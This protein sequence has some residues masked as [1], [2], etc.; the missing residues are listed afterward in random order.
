MGTNPFNSS[1][2]TSLHPSLDISGYLVIRTF[3]IF[4]PVAKRLHLQ[5][6]ENIWSLIMFGCQHTPNDFLCVDLDR[7]VGVK[8]HL[9]RCSHKKLSKYQFSVESLL[10]GKHTMIKHLVQDYTECVNISLQCICFTLNEHFR[11]H[12]G[13]STHKAAFFILQPR[14]KKFCQPKINEFHV[15]PIL[16]AQNIFWLDV[17]VYDIQS[18]QSFYTLKKLIEQLQYCYFSLLCRAQSQE[19][20]TMQQLAQ[21][22]SCCVVFIF[23]A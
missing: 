16:V 10:E 8:L 11:S 15:K 19:S 17:T 2:R 18:V 12:I 23:D 9:L 21:I 22:Y 20:S 6:L 3:S 4:S 1:S 7:D 13:W 5:N 14:L